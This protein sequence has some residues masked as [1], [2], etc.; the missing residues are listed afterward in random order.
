MVSSGKKMPSIRPTKGL[1][2]DGVSCL[3]LK[4]MSVYRFAE[5][6]NRKKNVAENLISRN[7]T[8]FDKLPPESSSGASSFG[9]ELKTSTIFLSQALCTI[10]YQL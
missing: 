6:Y 5:K 9:P 7:Q 8:I 4:F 2:A 10:Y 3:F 1:S